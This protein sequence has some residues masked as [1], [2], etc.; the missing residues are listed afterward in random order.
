MKRIL[1]LELVLIGAGLAGGSLMD[2]PRAVAQERRSAQFPAGRFDGIYLV[3][4]V[5]ESGSC[6]KSRWTAAVA[7][8]Q[9]ASV[10]PNPTNI[11]AL[12]L[13]ESNGVVSLTFR[14]AQNQI[15]HVGGMIKGRRGKG[16]WSSPTLLC[17]GIWRAQKEK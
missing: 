1:M 16:S 9:I 14:D 11:T 3:E 10:T 17:G 4:V 7:G 15:A 13:I 6:T 2:A 12:G 5:P 8:G